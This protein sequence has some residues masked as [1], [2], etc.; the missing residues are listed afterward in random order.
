MPALAPSAARRVRTNAD[1]EMVRATYHW[2]HWTTDA[3]GDTGLVRYRRDT[4][5]LRVHSDTGVV[6]AV[7]SVPTG[8]RRPNPGDRPRRKPARSG[9]RG[10]AGTRWPTTQAA[11]HGCASTAAS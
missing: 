4:C 8:N 9:R 2:P 5:E 1:R 6:H 7:F 3:A 10:G 11:L